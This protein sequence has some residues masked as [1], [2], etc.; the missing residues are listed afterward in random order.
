VLRWRSAMHTPAAMSPDLSCAD[1]CPHNPCNRII[2]L[3]RQAWYM[4]NL[5][6]LTVL[7]CTTDSAFVSLCQSC[8]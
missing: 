2:E 1:S 3:P 6:H 4:P 7:A 5:G 8:A